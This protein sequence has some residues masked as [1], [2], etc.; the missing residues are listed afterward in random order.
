MDVDQERAIDET[1]E[2]LSAYLLEETVHYVHNKRRGQSN[3]QLAVLFLAFWITSNRRLARLGL[4]AGWTC[5]AV[6]Y[7]T[8]SLQLLSRLMES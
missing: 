6:G 5:L 4:V 8:T 1:E 3:H 2:D 7:T